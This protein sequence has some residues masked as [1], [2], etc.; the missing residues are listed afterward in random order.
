MVEAQGAVLP[1]DGLHHGP[2]GAARRQGAALRAGGGGG[3]GEA[4]DPTPVARLAQSWAGRER[5]I[6]D[7]EGPGV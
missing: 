1:E 7:T 6:L 5:L 4:G 2:D 3:G